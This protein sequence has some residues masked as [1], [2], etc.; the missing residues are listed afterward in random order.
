MP[1]ISFKLIGGMLSINQLA[2]K[3]GNKVKFKK[4][5]FLIG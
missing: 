3:N 2:M 5:Y 1:T 4:Q